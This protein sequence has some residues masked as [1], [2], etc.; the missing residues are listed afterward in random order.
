M[1]TWWK[2][3]TYWSRNRRQIPRRALFTVTMAK[4]RV[5]DGMLHLFD[6]VKRTCRLI[7]PSGRVS[8]VVREIHV[9]LGHAGQRTTE[10]A[11]RQHFWWPK[12][13]DDVVRN[14][15]NCNICAQTDSPT[16]APK[17]LFQTVA[18]VGPNHRVG[19][20][21]IGPVPRSRMGNKYI[22]VIVGYFTIWCEAFPMPIQEAPIITSL[23]VNEWVA[24]FGKPI[25]LHSEQGAAF[26]S[27]LLEEVCRTLR[28]HET[29]TTP[30][31][32]QSNGLVERTN[33]TV[34]TILRAFIE[35]HQSNRWDE[36]LP[37]CLLAHRAA[38]HLSTGYTPSLLT[39][40]HG[41]R[42]PIKVLTS[43]ASAECIGS[44]HY[45]KELGERLR[46]AY[47]IAAQHQ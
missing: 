9:E 24:R 23:F 1:I 13:H 27:R 14:C 18:T 40:G 46:V 16:V 5:I 2:P 10:V 45:V 29:R 20:D 38:V 8:K 25:E 31:H 3:K 4:L 30:Y 17:V 21:V 34:M 33:R 6:R 15:A 39:L 42:S 7:L 43:L 36:I 44:P 19:V 41:L 47:K 22:L 35:Q 32:P 12:L 37:Q 28:I 11:V 26:E